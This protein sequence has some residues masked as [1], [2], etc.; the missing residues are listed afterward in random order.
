[1]DLSI[2]N[3][4]P[5]TVEQHQQIKTDQQYLTESVNEAL[6]KGLIQLQQVKP[7]NPSVRNN[8]I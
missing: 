1:M 7:A 4:K 3:L 5:L 8:F 6:I 2:D